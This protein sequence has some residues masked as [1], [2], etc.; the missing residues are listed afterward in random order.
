MKMLLEV[1]GKKPEQIRDFA[2]VSAVL[3][4]LDAAGPHSF[5]S[6]TRQDGSYVQA[7]GGRQLCL[8]ER[9]EISDNSHWRAVHIE[10]ASPSSGSKTL[11]FGGGQVKL[12]AQEIF[13][14][15]EVITVW[16]AF[17]DSTPLPEEIRWR[18][19]TSMFQGS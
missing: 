12:S 14:I 2:K 17:F 10:C 8:I 11:I 18:N 13:S 16:R 4:E 7:A 19:I 15:D 3:N 5:A 1:E 6:L 9:R